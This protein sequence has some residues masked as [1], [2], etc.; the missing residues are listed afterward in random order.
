MVSGPE[1]ARLLKKFEEDY[2]PKDKDS[3]CGY[4]HEEGFYTQKFQ[5]A[6]CESGSG[7]Q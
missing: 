5:G 4:H 1:Q 7:Q 2:L 3:D 6:G